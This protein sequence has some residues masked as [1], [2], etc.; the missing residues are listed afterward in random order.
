MDNIKC[1]KCGY[2]FDYSGDGD[3]C[4]C[5]LC[6]SEINVS[7]G[8]E[9]FKNR[10]DSNATTYEKKSTGKIILDWAIFGVSFAAFIVILYLIFDFIVN[11]G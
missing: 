5:P 2:T 8:R 6:S 9:N 11:F 4:T 1:T 10:V 7:D 3:S